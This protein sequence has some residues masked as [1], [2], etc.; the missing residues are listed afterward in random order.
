MKIL[1]RKLLSI[2]YYYSIFHYLFSSIL[3]IKIG[4]IYTLS[5]I[6]NKCFSP[7][8]F[9]VIKLINYFITNDI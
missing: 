9:Q 1:K 7:S 6:F 5:T 3:I 4:L 8:I 2:I